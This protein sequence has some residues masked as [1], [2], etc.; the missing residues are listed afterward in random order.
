MLLAAIA[1]LPTSS[2]SVGL[3]LEVS[4]QVL[5]VEPGG[6]LGRQGLVVVDP[7]SVFEADV[8]DVLLGVDATRVKNHQDLD[9]ALAGRAPGERVVLTVSRE[10]ERIEI[11]TRL[12][13]GAGRDLSPDLPHNFAPASSMTFAKDPEPVWYGWQMIPFDLLAIGL[14]ITAAYVRGPAG[15]AL[16]A[17]GIA[18]YSVPSPLIH[19]AH[20]NDK[21]A[22]YSAGARV[23]FPLV[24]AIVGAGGEFELATSG[25]TTELRI[26]SGSVI[27]LVIMAIAMGVDYAILAF[28]KPS[29]R[30]FEW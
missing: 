15:T 13:A 17:S 24:V 21:G 6:V 1:A 12:V 2:A 20:D 11:E 9:R 25:T 27:A 19:L 28:E 18:V 8:G 7:G 30:D 10:G 16:L 14:G 29:R 3:P 26:G 5:A 4:Q 23:L 22:L